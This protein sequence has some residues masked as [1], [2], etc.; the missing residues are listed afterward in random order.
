[1]TLIE[2]LKRW[3]TNRQPAAL[4]TWMT[5]NCSDSGA[6]I[7]AAPPGKEPWQQH[8]L[9]DRVERICFTDGCLYDSDEFA[10]Y[11]T[12]QPQPYFI[13]LDAKGGAEF[14]K[15]VRDRHLFPDEVSAIAVRAS[16]GETICWPAT[17]VPS[18]S[19]RQDNATG[20]AIG[21]A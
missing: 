20:N 3:R 14:W 9:W 2:R 1:M 7:S 8:F 18:I 12:E 4:E 17:D 10:V 11:T 16:A 5:I 6:T 21:S 15:W 13:P 19:R